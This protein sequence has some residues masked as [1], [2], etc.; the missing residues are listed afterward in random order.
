MRKK[1]VAVIILSGAKSKN[2]AA[3]V[4]L[5]LGMTAFWHTKEIVAATWKMNMTQL[6]DVAALSKKN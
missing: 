3:K 2:P 1:I 5:S 4:R 6:P